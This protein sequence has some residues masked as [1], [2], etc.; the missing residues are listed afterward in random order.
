MSRAMFSLMGQ[1]QAVR[2]AQKKAR[3]ARTFGHRGPFKCREGEPIICEACGRAAIAGTLCVQKP[4]DTATPPYINRIS[5]LNP[6]PVI[7]DD[8]LP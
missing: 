2:R 4:A 6:G 5:G 8:L 7:E 1:G 3:R